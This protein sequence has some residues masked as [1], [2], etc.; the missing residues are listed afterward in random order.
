MGA[1]PSCRSRRRGTGSTATSWYCGRPPSPPTAFA[2]GGDGFAPG[3][4]PGE[5]APVKDFLLRRLGAP[6]TEVRSGRARRRAF[7]GRAH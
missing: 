2:T 6:G 5:S 4:R 3:G 1:P 7:A